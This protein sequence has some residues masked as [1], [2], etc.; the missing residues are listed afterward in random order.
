MRTVS[1]EDGRRQLGE[2][3]DVARLA[4]EPT[5]ITRHG[6]AAAMLVS[7]SWY[8]DAE[9]AMASDSDGPATSRRD[10]ARP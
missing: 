1:I 5:L 10:G 7:V 6:K 9:A 4:G 3:V 8:E 2:L